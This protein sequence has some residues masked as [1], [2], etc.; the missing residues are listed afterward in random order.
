MI[1]APLIENT[2]F[3]RVLITGIFSSVAFTWLLI[4]FAS[5]RLDYEVFVLSIKEWRKR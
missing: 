1:D 2:L 4:C 3:N 5:A